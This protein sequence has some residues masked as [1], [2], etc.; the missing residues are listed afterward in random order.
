MPCLL[1]P[2]IVVIDEMLPSPI[3]SQNCGP[4]SPACDEG[5]IILPVIFEFNKIPVGGGK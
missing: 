3:H 5:V 4:V 2:N 1:K